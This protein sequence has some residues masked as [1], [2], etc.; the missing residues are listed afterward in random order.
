METEI[1]AFAGMTLRRIEI[2]LPTYARG[3][4]HLTILPPPQRRHGSRIG[5]QEGLDGQFGE[6]RRA[7]GAEDHRGADKGHQPPGGFELERYGNFRYQLRGF[8][9][10]AVR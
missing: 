2:A 9:L 8:E 10:E 7:R 1:P 6:G 5:G 4:R 3:F